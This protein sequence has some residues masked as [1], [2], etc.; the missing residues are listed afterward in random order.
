MEMLCASTH[1]VVTKECVAPVSNS[2][3][4]G[5]DSNEKKYLLPHLV[6]P[7]LLLPQSG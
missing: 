2:T 1:D 6:H 5:W 4:A 3:Y 7:G